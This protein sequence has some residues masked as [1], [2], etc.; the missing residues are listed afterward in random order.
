MAPTI[1]I[2]QE[3]LSQLDALLVAEMPQEKNSKQR[4]TI[5]LKIQENHLE[6]NSQYQVALLLT[7]II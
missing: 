1:K 2:R 5:I 4:L 7:L 6:H 3:W